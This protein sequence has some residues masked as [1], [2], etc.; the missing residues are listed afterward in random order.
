MVWYGINR[1]DLYNLPRLSNTLTL[2]SSDLEVNTSSLKSLTVGLGKILTSIGLASV[3][4]NVVLPFT[5]AV[6]LLPLLPPANS[7]AHAGSCTDVERVEL[8]P[9]LLTPCAVIVPITAP[10]VYDTVRLMVPWPLTIVAPVVG[11]VH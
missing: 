8:I 10:S 6:P 11:I 5:V 7:V 9:Q 2:I 3:F 1:K 4:G